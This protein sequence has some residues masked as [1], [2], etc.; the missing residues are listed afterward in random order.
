MVQDV[1]ISLEYLQSILQSLDPLQLVFN[2]SIVKHIFPSLSIEDERYSSLRILRFFG[3]RMRVFSLVFRL[4]R[5]MSSETI[6]RSGGFTPLKYTNARW[7]YV[8]IMFFC[9]E[10]GFRDS[11]LY[12]LEINLDLKNH[13]LSSGHSSYM[14]I[15]AHPISLKNKGVSGD[16]Y[17]YT[18]LFVIF[19]IKIMCVRI[20]IPRPTS[21]KIIIDT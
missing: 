15:R 16:V 5:N 1:A 3:Y 17:P 6:N 10:K 13:M 19:F 7:G 11:Y 12:Y 4:T 14:H 9:K 18:P 21:Y 8:F 20:W 2:S